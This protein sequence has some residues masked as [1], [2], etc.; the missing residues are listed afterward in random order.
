MSLSVGSAASS[1]LANWQQMLQTGRAGGGKSQSFDPLAALMQPGTGNAS[2]AGIS[3]SS[4]L[5]FGQGMMA[6]LI[7]LQQQASTAGTTNTHDTGSAKLFAKLD[8]DGNGSVSKSELEAAASKHGVSTSISDAVFAKIDTDGDDNISH[9]ELAKADRPGAGHHQKEIGAGDSGG[10]DSADG[11]G[12]GAKTSTTTNAD[13][14]VT[15]TIT[16]ADGS[17]ASTTSPPAATA[18][19]GSADPT[20]TPT[21]NGGSDLFRQLAQLQRQMMSAATTTLSAVA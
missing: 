2:P 6:Q 18:N 13:G 1:P 20:S 19:D 7:A 17:R 15:T 11:D 3:A 8:A 16:Y 21:G 12:N 9:S 10:G 4:S 14:S 5:P